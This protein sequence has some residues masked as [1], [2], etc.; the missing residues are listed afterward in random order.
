LNKFTDATIAYFYAFIFTEK[1]EKAS[2]KLIAL[3]IEELR[4]L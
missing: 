1:G 4:D 2:K 3:C